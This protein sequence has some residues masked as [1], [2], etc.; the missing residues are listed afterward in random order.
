MAYL[1]PKKKVGQTKDSIAFVQ[2]PFI[3]NNFKRWGSNLDPNAITYAVAQADSGYPRTYQ[4]MLLELRQTNGALQAV[5]QARELAISGMEYTVVAAKDGKKSSADAEKKA[6]VCAKRLSEM[7]SFEDYIKHLV[8]ADYHGYSVSEFIVTKTV[9]EKKSSAKDSKN[10]VKKIDEYYYNILNHVPS[11]F[12]FTKEQ[13]LIYDYT[14]EGKYNDNPEDNIL[15]KSPLN[16]SIHTP[17]VTGS[18]PSQE[19]L[20]RGAVWYG[21]FRNWAWRNLI[22]YS[23]EYG[24]PYRKI[25]YK[26]AMIEDEDLTNAL[27]IAQNIGPQNCIIHSD[28]LEVEMDWF[29]AANSF[30]DSPNPTVISLSELELSMMFLGQK[31]SLSE[32]TAGLGGNGDVRDLLRKDIRKANARSIAS[33]VKYDLLSLICL[34]EFG[35]TDNIPDLVFNTGDDPDLESLFSTLTIA[36]NDLGL[37]IPKAWVHEISKFPMAPDSDDDV[38]GEV[39]QEE[40]PNMQ[41]NNQDPAQPDNNQQVEEDQQAN[42]E[43]NSQSQP[44]KKKSKS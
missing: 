29:S 44:E 10:G 17:R 19:G 24:K 33:R 37:R 15:Y 32:V 40:D 34:I 30:S 27:E 9:K 28:A 2:V 8:S 4:N 38:L 39:D 43:T 20:G 12:K 25:T 6:L 42:D 3:G 22:V 21:S 35:N 41:G 11:L 23:D 26:E 18:E 36:V 31:M 5:A 7:D 1:T 14:V 16:F 13:I